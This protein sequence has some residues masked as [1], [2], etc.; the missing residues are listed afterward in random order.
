MALGAVDS[1]KTGRGGNVI[2]NDSGVLLVAFSNAVPCFAR[3]FRTIVGL[4]LAAATT[5]WN[6]CVLRCRS[7]VSVQPNELTAYITAASVRVDAMVP[8]AVP[9][10]IGDALFF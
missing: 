3:L 4:T 6:V 9:L 1:T 7:V 5:I 10:R 2:I 8:A